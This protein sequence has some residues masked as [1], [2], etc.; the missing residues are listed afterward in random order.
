MSKKPVLHLDF[1][2]RSDLDLT[3]VGLSI[4]A[5][6][7]NTDILCAAWAFDDEPV[8]LW[9]PGQE[10]PTRFINHI[11]GGGEVWAHNAAF[12]RDICNHVGVRKY[13]WPKLSNEQLN[14]TMAMAY[15][16]GL[17]GS[18]ENCAS[19]LGIEQRKDPE[20][21]RIMKQFCQPRGLSPTGTI[22][23]WDE[24]EKLEK[25]Y[26]YCKQDVVVERN[27]GHRMLKLS[28]Y[29]QKVWCMDQV[30]NE[31]GIKVDLKAAFAAS[32]IIEQEKAALNVEIREI[33]SGEIASC[34]SVA[35]IKKYLLKRGF[36]KVESL[37]KPSVLEI[38]KGDVP[39]E[40]RRVLELRQSA[41]KASTAKL[42]PMISG[43][44]N[45]HRIRGS[46]QYNGANTRRWAGRRVQLQNLVKPTLSHE[47]IEKIINVLPSLSRDEFTMLF[48]DPIPVM[49][50]LIRAFLIPEKGHL[51]NV[52]DF[53]AIEARVAAWLA[54]E[55]TVLEVFRNDQDIY[56]RAAQAI[57]GTKTISKEQRAVGKVAVLALGYGGGVGALQ[58]MARSFSVKM[59]PAFE[60]L[61][62]RI[63][64]TQMDRIHDS[65]N[66]YVK[67]QEA[68]NDSPISFEEFASSD[69]TKILWREANP[70]IV[71][72]WSELEAAAVNATL[73]PGNI[74]KA[75]SIAFKKSGSFLFCRLPSAG[76]IS[77]P[78]PEIQ[79]VKTPWGAKRDALTYMT[80]DST[81]RKWVRVSTYGGS[82]FENVCQSVARDLLADAM[83]RVESMGFPIVMHVH[84]EIVC[85]LPKIDGS[86]NLTKMQK[87]MNTLPD[88]AWG[89]PLATSGFACERYRK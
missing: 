8:E 14:C 4:Y 15:A 69:M 77:Y 49:S 78:Y 30:I 28:P 79:K 25:L 16:M 86:L 29:E 11:Y 22:L 34:T 67:K 75:N 76:V 33:S 89:L 6:G 62:A 50:N 48:G 36:E 60:A 66:A 5:K 2:T 65:Y 17:P 32:I 80:E 58:I 64:E 20:G 1:E 9:L 70:N 85:E 19:A 88:W 83:L 54:H 43:A 10:L 63:S 71:S 59:A 87:A 55:E 51:F 37:D 45:D 7:K 52:M 26:L 31:R 3:S 74:F 42:D 46:F 41:A 61:S 47:T 39:P 35:Q 73:T 13:G 27:A 82:L 21:Y 40:I 12:E 68:L 38:L 53:N 18:L 84:D 57:F 23:W 72:Y 56:V 81:S 44:A 24:P